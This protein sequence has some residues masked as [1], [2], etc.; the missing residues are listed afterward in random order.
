[1]KRLREVNIG[2]QVHYMPINMNPYY[3][4]LGY[5]G[6]D[7]PNAMNYYF[8]TLSIPVFPGIKKSQQRFI[9]RKLN[10]ILEES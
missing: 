10:H 2:T 1:M 4:S 8:S 7:T 6:V 9:I 5:V 3:E